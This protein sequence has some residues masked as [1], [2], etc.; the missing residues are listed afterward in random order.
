MTDF[1]WVLKAIVYYVKRPR[2]H[3]WAGDRVGRTGRYFA[4]DGVKIY[5]SDRGMFQQDRTHIEQ[6]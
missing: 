3:G 4:L 6:I 1:D 2:Q 5:Q